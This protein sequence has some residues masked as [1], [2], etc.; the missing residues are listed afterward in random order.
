[1]SNN[2][3]EQ[4]VWSAIH[5]WKKH[6]PHIGTE[7]VSIS[8]GSV[9]AVFPTEILYQREGDIDSEHLGEMCGIIKDFMSEM[10]DNQNQI[11][12]IEDIEPTTNLRETEF[13]LAELSGHNVIGVMP[14]IY[15]ETYGI[16]IDK[17]KTLLS[18]APK[19]ISVRAVV[20]R[21][22]QSNHIQAQNAIECL[23]SSIEHHRTNDAQKF[24]KIIIDEN[25][26]I[27]VLKQ[28]FE[29]IAEAW[30]TDDRVEW[31]SGA[32]LYTF[33]IIILPVTDNIEKIKKAKDIL[34]NPALNLA[35][36]ITVDIT[37][38]F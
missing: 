15:I 13:I 37:Y 10:E 36:N 21:S 30:G 31:A 23:A 35:Q 4:P 24:L 2:N 20:P 28:Y 18:Y 27:D 5:G 22:E 17:F 14:D 3:S 8:N 29:T 34:R 33:D 12:L 11:I 1:M 26:D 6:A 9:N 16:N 7:I 38:L 19:S 25:S 32:A